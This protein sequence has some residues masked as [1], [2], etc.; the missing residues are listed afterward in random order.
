[1]GAQFVSYTCGGGRTHRPV[2]IF[3]IFRP[4]LA[5][6]S[7]RTTADLHQPPFR[8]A[9]AGYRRPLGR[10]TDPNGR[11]LI[12]FVRLLHPNLSSE[13]VT[14]TPL[15]SLSYC[16]RRKE[17]RGLEEVWETGKGVFLPCATKDVKARSERDFPS[18]PMMIKRGF[19]R[20][21]C[22]YLYTPTTTLGECA[23]PD[24]N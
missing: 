13:Y 11:E 24:K 14:E 2:A 10:R 19:R 16:E 6:L 23:R 22:F 18:A 21:L 5:R 7:S 9:T 4:N 3:I 1:M 20:N 15:P 12:I 8:A 17:K